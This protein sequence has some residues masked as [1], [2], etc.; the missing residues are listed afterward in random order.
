MNLEECKDLPDGKMGVWKSSG[1]ILGKRD[2]HGQK[3]RG[4]NFKVSQRISVL[5]LWNVQ[6]LGKVLKVGI[7]KIKLWLD[8]E[9]I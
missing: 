4:M 5:C 1:C 2:Q 8:S 9:S 7:E 6:C 3:F